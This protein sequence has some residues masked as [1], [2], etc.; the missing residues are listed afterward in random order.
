MWIR[1]KW[2]PWTLAQFFFHI[3]ENSH[4]VSSMAEIAKFSFSFY[5]RSSADAPWVTLMNEFTELNKNLR[6]MKVSLVWCLGKDWAHTVTAGARSH[7]ELPAGN[8]HEGEQG[9]AHPTIPAREQA[10]R[11]PLS[12]TARRVCGDTPGLGPSWKVC[13]SGSG[14]TGFTT[15]QGWDKAGDRVTYNLDGDRLKALGWAEMGSTLMPFILL[16]ALHKTRQLDNSKPV[17]HPSILKLKVFKRIKQLHSLETLLSKYMSCHAGPYC[18]V[19]VGTLHNRYENV[20]STTYLAALSQITVKIWIVC[21]YRRTL[22]VPINKFK[23]I[24]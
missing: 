18:S 2:L 3:T 12:P 9:W 14:W 1:Q 8:L 13:K 21:K 23:Q 10:A 22:A 17:S 11:A 7:V 15:R 20:I 6:R 4:E 19:C 16:R 5:N 24:C